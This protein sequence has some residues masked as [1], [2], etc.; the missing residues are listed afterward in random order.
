MPYIAALAILI[1]V[2]MI[3]VYSTTAV[4]GIKAL[5]K[6]GLWLAVGLPGIWIAT[7][8]PMSLW[9]KASGWLLVA[10]F[11]ALAS[12]LLKSHNPLA[13][14]VNGA[15]RWIKVPALGQIQPSEV[16]KLAFVLFAAKFLERRGQR[17]DGTQWLT[18]LGVL[19]ALAAVIYKEPD[20]GTT[21]VLGGIALCML[22]ASGVRWGLLFKGIVVVAA[23]V[24]VAAW[25][26]PHQRERLLVWW[27]PWKEEYRQEGGYQVIQSW[28]A[29]TRGGVG[30]VG[31]GRSIY[32][33][34]D[35]LPEAETDFIF[36]IVAEE[37]GLVRAVLVLGVF[38]L[39]AWRGFSIASRAPDR[40]SALVATGVT[41]WV[42]VQACLNTAVVTGTFPNT[43]VPLPFI[44]SGGSS[45]CTLMIAS[46]IVIGISQRRPVPPAQEAAVR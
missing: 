26:T 17:M 40:Y 41:S 15:Y 46:G 19:A 9:K 5:T 24:A 30:G 21:L 12:L 3:M 13:V 8:I 43:G 34:E 20:L 18:F 44:S 10:C 11:L 6:M 28:S 16:A 25:S 22:I 1:S 33:L 2:G 36:A 31:L 42:A 37:M 27:N 4:D 39:L 38:V 29:M 14:E 45:L 23:I 32:K 7:R 35:R